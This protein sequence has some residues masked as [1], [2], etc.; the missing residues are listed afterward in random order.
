M[1]N[2]GAYRPLPQNHYCYHK[3][4]LQLFLHQYTQTWLLILTI[5]QLPIYALP[6][7]SQ[8]LSTIQQSRTTLKIKLQ[9]VRIMLNCTEW[10]KMSYFL[11][12]QCNNSNS[13]ENM[14]TWQSFTR[15]SISKLVDI[16]SDRLTQMPHKQWHIRLEHALWFPPQVTHKPTNTITTECPTSLW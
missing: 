13:G 12:N 1:L 2:L 5:L 8:I 9:K 14:L 15:H 3:L 4:F 11:A 7:L 10:D 16:V 6:T